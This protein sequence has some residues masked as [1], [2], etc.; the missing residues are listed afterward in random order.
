ML[1][2]FVIYRYIHKQHVDVKFCSQNMTIFSF[3]HCYTISNDSEYFRAIEH[4]VCKYHNGIRT[5]MRKMD[6]AQCVK[7]Y[8]SAF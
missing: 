4:P 3:I 2:D 1:R 5:S 6:A 7:V 8:Y